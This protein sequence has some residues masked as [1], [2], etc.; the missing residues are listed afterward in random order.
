MAQ[1]E[2]RAEQQ[3]SLRRHKLPSLASRLTVTIDGVGRYRA[4]PQAGMQ[5]KSNVNG[6]FWA[7]QLH[8]VTLVHKATAGVVAVLDFTLSVE[9][10]HPSPLTGRLFE[11]PEADPIGPVFRPESGILKYL[12]S[13]MR[14]DGTCREV[15]AITF[16]LN[17]VLVAQMGGHENIDHNNCV[18][19]V[20]DAI[21]GERIE[22]VASQLDWSRFGGRPGG[23]QSSS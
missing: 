14:L 8:P 12:H 18:L 6:D 2:E 19:Y 21:T 22:V 1:A 16:I 11:V 17:P 20:A 3:L 5:T 7:I 15:G 10:H 23:K 13:N 4:S 9:L